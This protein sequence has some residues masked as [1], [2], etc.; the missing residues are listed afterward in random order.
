MLKESIRRYCGLRWER[1]CSSDFPLPSLATIILKALFITVSC[2]MSAGEGGRE[3][4]GK[5]KKYFPK[6]SLHL[7]SSI[8]LWAYFHSPLLLLLLLF[9]RLCGHHLAESII[10]VLR[11]RSD[12]QL[13]RAV[14]V[15]GGSWS[16][17]LLLTVQRLD[18]VGFLR[19]GT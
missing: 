12:K 3:K 17:R 11:R 16:K 2:V 1:F 5:K 8:R 10:T 4:R 19:G 15:C 9:P 6:Q 7:F 14:N 13:S 18:W